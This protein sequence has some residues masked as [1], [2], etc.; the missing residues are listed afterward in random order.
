MGKA[1]ALL[2][3]FSLIL[4]LLFLA[5]A[6]LTMGF[7]AQH[8]EAGT[9]IAAVPAIS[10]IVPNAAPRDSI[11]EISGTDFG[12]TQGTSYVTFGS[13]KAVVYPV[14]TS[15]YIAV[16][17]P[18]VTPAGDQEQINVTVTTG[19]GT[20]NA[21]KFDVVQYGVGLAEGYTGDNFQEYLCI[22]NMQNVAV[23]ASIVFLYSDGEVGGT[24]VT[25][26]SNSRVTVD[27]NEEAGAG[28]EVSV[29]VFSDLQLVVE[30][31][32][33]FN[34]NGRWTGGH[35]VI[36]T[37]YVSKLWFFAEGYT[38]A[39][40]DEWICVLNPNET[41]TA[42]LTFHFQ[43]KS[44]GEI[45]KTGSVPAA[46]RESFKVNELLGSNQECSLILESDQ[47]VVAERPMYFD[48]EGKGAHHWEGGHCV[49]GLPWPS[50][51]YFFAE[52]CTRDGFEE[53]LT[54][55]NPNAE[56]I[57]VNVTYQLGIGQGNPIQKTYNVPA[58]SR[59]TIYVADDVGLERDV[60]IKATS[61][62]YFLAERPMYFR[63]TGYGAGYEGG[64]CVIG[65]GS[66]SSD[67]FFAE[68]Y[69]GQ[70][71]QEWLCL[72][73][74]GDEDSVVDIYYLGKTGV[75]AVKQVTVSARSRR[76]LRVNDEAGANLELSCHIVVVA[77]SQIV[78]ERPM[79]FNFRGW[80]GGHD[81]IGYYPESD[82]FAASS[83]EATGKSQA[84]LL[85]DLS[86]EWLR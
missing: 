66:T 78:A 17:V 40:F 39:G 13:T 21:V 62:D 37:P 12:A 65:A 16:K 75:A 14:W 27:V 71:F 43:T 38:G 31:P 45:D 33:Y 84:A 57:S 67:W 34:Y 80:D 55:Q 69:T 29:I 10:T 59:S 77:G 11:V 35:D 1:G 5:L 70:G 8:V 73:N 24:E 58:E 41:A 44:S 7:P 20:S 56:P 9:V 30:R 74:P 63:Y 46:S 26:P 49:M 83:N 86:W 81:V 32:M 23:D 36:A 76:T 68:G 6:F 22:G 64:H 19:E 82:L 15:T 28:F 48:Y 54:L 4:L 85:N 72:Q 53:W 42:N 18:R 3:K 47:F 61:D 79:Y 50:T 51:E 2:G 25:V 60:S 52:G